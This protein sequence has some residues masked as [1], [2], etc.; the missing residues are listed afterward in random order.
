[1]GDVL[2]A[3]LKVIG[4]KGPGVCDASILP[5]PVAAGPMA[6]LYAITEQMA[7]LNVRIVYLCNIIRNIDTLVAA[8]PV[9]SAGD[10]SYRR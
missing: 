7:E 1:M 4:T 9:G 8:S 6:A 5:A 10:L 3:D 2:G